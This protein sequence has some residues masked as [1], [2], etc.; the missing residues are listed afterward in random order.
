MFKYLSMCKPEEGLTFDL[1]F[2][3]LRPVQVHGSCVSIQGVDGVGVRQQL[4]Q[5]RLKDVGEVCWNSITLN[6]SIFQ[7]DL[8]VKP[9]TNQR[10]QSIL[11]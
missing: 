9:R 5:E 3:V 11:E 4:G 8:Q 10:I 7:N 1:V 6:T 2:V